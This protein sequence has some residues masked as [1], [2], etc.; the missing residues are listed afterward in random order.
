M[1]R[2]KLTAGMMALFLS[3]VI[4]LGTAIDTKA[5]DNGP[6][7]EQSPLE[8]DLTGKQTVSIPYDALLMLNDVG[9]FPLSKEMDSIDFNNDGKPDVSVKQD[10]ETGPFLL[11]RLDGANLLKQDYTYDLSAFGSQYSTVT[12][13]V[14]S[15]PVSVSGVSLDQSNLTLKVGEVHALK[16]NVLP[17]DAANKNVIWSSSAPKVAEVDN[18]GKVTAKAAGTATITVTTT[19]G[20][21]TATCSVTVQEKTY[22]VTLS[23]SANVVYGSSTKY[24]VSVKD[25]ENTLVTGANVTLKLLNSS[26][27]KIVWT[28]S[29]SVNQA[30]KFQK[31][32]SFSQAP[33]IYKMVAEYG[34]FKS[35]EKTIKV[36]KAKTKLTAKKKQFA[37]KTDTKKYT[38]V[39]NNNKNKALKKQKLILTINKKTYKATTNSKGEAT[40]KIT[41]LTKHGK[42]KAT[43][44]YKGNKYYKA[45]SKKTIITI[46]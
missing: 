16:A 18:N 10:K 38:V 39:L 31:S 41:K 46:K 1:K 17:E 30:G 9:G 12:F 28:I 7:A 23:G 4:A 43:I 35:K 3:L 37:A 25:E 21:K 19:D 34:S 14:V 5:D 44:K 15:P 36:N 24:T 11:T 27:K 26:E 8:M 29:V 22:T 33:G 20:G 2:T 32:V 40:F 13:L 45:I 42:Y 6:Q